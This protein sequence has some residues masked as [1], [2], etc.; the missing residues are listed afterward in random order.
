MRLIQKVKDHLH[1]ALA[2]VNKLPPFQ[3]SVLVTSQV[4]DALILSF[5]KSFCNI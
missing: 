2:Q 4:N 3:G 1:T 5:C